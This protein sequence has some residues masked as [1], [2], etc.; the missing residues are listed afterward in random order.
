MFGV[1]KCASAKEVQNHISRI[2]S[3]L[4]GGQDVKNIRHKRFLPYSKLCIRAENPV[5]FA[6]MRSIWYSRCSTTHQATA[7]QTSEL[8][9]AGYVE[10]FAEK[11]SS[12]AQLEKLH[13]LRA[14]L[15]ALQE[16]EVSNHDRLA[17]T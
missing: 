8:K 7:I 12:P 14:F 2:W 10:V 4:K 1:L 6:M 15:E 17:R 9:N 11:V 13:Q 5:G 3:K 16:E